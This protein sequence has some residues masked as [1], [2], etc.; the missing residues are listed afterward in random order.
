LPS[1]PINHPAGGN[2]LLRALAPEDMDALRPALENVILAKD[3]AVFQPG[4][5]AS[6]VWFPDS[7]M[8]SIVALDDQG[9]AIEVATIGHQGMTGLAALLGS[10]TTIFSA[11][12]QLPGDGRR[13]ESSAF[14]QL[15]D[16][17]PAIR[18][19]ML[20]YVLAAMTQMGQNVACGQL[21]NTEARCARWLLLA[22][23]DAGSDSFPLTQ[24]Y[25]A[26]M[27]GVT[28]P[29]VSA[30]AS[31]LQKAGLIRY[32][33]GRMDIVNRPGLEAVSC[34]CYTI[35]RDEFRRLLVSA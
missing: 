19:V 9:S 29:S 4:E 10:D 32:V 2:S 15:L 3:H 17:R 14:R 28:R 26:M 35:V 5:P 18:T 21:H 12:V 24:D 8:I 11:M 23:D 30:A 7:G 16:R 22:H 25:L 31:A 1:F 27:L 6:H 33:R 20:R 13:I 34:E